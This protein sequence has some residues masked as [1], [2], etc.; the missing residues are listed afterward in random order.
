LQERHVR[1]IAQGPDEM[2]WF[3]VGLKK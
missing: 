2:C 1:R 3:H